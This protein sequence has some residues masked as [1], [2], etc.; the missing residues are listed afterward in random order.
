MDKAQQD[1]Y[2]KLRVKIKKWIETHDQK[3]Q[4]WAEYIL[5]APDIFH[6]LC[7]LAM[8]PEVPTSKKVKLGVVIAYFISPLDFLPEMILGPIGYLDDIALSAF[9]LNDIINNTNPKVITRNWAGERDILDLVKT[10]LVN[11]DKMVGSGLWQKLK[12]KLS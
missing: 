2:Q 4:K 11:A 3:D 12:N 1:F 8:D 6:L 7:K 5:L 9:I 10:I